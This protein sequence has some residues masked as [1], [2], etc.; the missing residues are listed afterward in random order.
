MYKVGFVSV[1]R[2][3][4]KL[5]FGIQVSNANPMIKRNF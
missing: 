1:L 4:M 3:E 5:F 2:L